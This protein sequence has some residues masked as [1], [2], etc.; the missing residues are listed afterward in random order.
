M[1]A[2]TSENMING[3]LVAHWNA[4]KR[5]PDLIV[6]DLDYTLWPLHVD[7]DIELPLRKESGIVIDANGNEIEPFEDIE[8]ILVTLKD[9]CLIP[10]QQHLAVA[11]KAQCSDKALALIETLGWK[12]YF[13]SFQIYSEPK[14]NHLKTLRDEFKLDNF[15]QILFFDDH[16]ANIK[17][18]NVLGVITHKIDRSIGLN[19]N[20]FQK[21]LDR[22]NRVYA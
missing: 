9:K 15:N 19:V 8:E 17:A 22:F 3:F 20:E 6:F 5:K 2:N 13:S 1:A 10:G 11:S 7:Y 14:T 21:G 18:V 12:K 16:P 4:L